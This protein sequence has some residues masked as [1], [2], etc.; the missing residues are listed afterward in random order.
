M[1]ADRESLGNWIA[2]LKDS[3]TLIIVEGETDEEALAFFGIPNVE[4]MNGKPLYMIVEDISEEHS[5]VIL[6]TDLD[7][8]G[9]NHHS[10]L[11]RELNQCGVQVD[12]RFRKYLAHI[13]LAHVQGLKT[14]VRNH[15]PK[16]Y[17][18]LST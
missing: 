3:E 10:R 11:R 14:Y 5:E 12:D 4:S 8:A 15:F 17:T 9:N 2:K 16:L 1:K 7:K 6:L 13:G 18:Q